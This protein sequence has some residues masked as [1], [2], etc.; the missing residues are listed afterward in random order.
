[1]LK[2]RIAAN[3][4]KAATLTQLRILILS[5]PLFSIPVITRDYYIMG[6]LILANV[7]AVF[8]SSWDLLFL[9]GQA[10]FGHAI[11]FGVA[12]YSVGILTR[13]F[14]L[15]PLAT[16]PAGIILAVITSIL[17]GVP[18]LRLKGMYLTLLTFVLVIILNKTVYTF[19]VQLGGEEGIPG[20]P[21][22]FRDRTY[23]YSLIMLIAVIT[24]I[25]VFTV[26]K[27]K[28]GIIFKAISDNEDAAEAAGIDTPKYKILAFCLSAFFAGL[29]GGLYA[30]NRR[31]VGP[32]SLNVMTSF[33]AVMYCI[34]GGVGT[35]YGPFVGA[36]CLIIIS[37]L[38]RFTVFLRLLLYSVIFIICALYLPRG[39]APPLISG[40][41]KIWE[42]LKEG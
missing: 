29:A 34:F 40:V 41:K 1:M 2:A 28:A 14:G 16:I 17:V 30:Y 10:S 31:H 33:M 39:V 20:I 21:P 13:D 27:S 6:V 12:A 25:I 11:F 19:R 37:E 32:D 7:Y 36:Y 8:A 35:I 23:E 18:C 9:T 4:K 24:L 5:L 38:L 3:L 22:L 42:R 26:A 15:P